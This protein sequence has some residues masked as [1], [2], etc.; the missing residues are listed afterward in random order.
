MFSNSLRKMRS[1][2]RLKSLKKKGGEKYVRA[3][4]SC[5]IV[6]TTEKTDSI[7]PQAINTNRRHT[8]PPS[9]LDE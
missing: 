9:N 7:S 1:R 4:P 5:Q 2:T 6:F 3:H 8:S